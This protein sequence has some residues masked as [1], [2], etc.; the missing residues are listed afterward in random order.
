MPDSDALRG[1][2]RPRK[3][4]PRVLAP[5]RLGRE[6]RVAVEALV[7]QATPPQAVLGVH[8]SRA[9]LTKRGARALAE[10]LTLWVN[11]S[12]KLELWG[13]DGIVSECGVSRPTVYAW[14]KRPD[15][16]KPVPVL[17]GN[18]QVWEAAKVRA[19]VK[20]ARPAMGRPPG[21]KQKAPRRRGRRASADTPNS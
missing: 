2:L 3:P 13:V 16:P 12:P 14:A 20:L 6:H 8:G 4:P 5:L 21:K 17:G 19:W 15:F 10:W 18:G 1:R 7:N 11:P 9:V